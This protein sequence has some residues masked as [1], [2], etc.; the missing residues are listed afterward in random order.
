MTTYTTLPC[1]LSRHLYQG[2]AVDYILYICRYPPPPH[3]HVLLC[4]K[5]DH[6]DNG[7]QACIQRGETELETRGFIILYYIIQVEIKEN[8]EK[9]S[10]LNIKHWRFRYWLF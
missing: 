3:V 6:R 4:S 5:E 8:V 1:S 10:V 7:G 9:N 2:V